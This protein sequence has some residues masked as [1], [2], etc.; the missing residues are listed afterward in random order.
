M[1]MS[2]RLPSEVRKV[3]REGCHYLSNWHTAYPMADQKM[4]LYNC[5]L[6][7]FVEVII[8]TPGQS[9]VYEGLNVSIIHVCFF[10]HE[11]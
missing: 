3:I 6:G 5:D 11:Y 8:S 9:P 2:Y 1:L 4:T 7:E 10:I